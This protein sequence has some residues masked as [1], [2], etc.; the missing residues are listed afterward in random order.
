MHSQ[1]DS[2][3]TFPTGKSCLAIDCDDIPLAIIVRRSTSTA[4]CPATTAM[5]YARAIAERNSTSAF[6]YDVKL[7][8]TIRGHP[9]H[10]HSIGLTIRYVAQGNQQMSAILDELA[11][12]N[13]C[14]RWC[15]Q[16]SASN[17]S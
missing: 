8:S 2:C 15:S 1:D 11:V 13:E 5:M 16:R 7:E 6:A 9:K 4:A 3:S 17:R 14:S 10:G 12:R